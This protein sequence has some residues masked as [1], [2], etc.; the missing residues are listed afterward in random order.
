MC[1]LLMVVT[2]ATLGLS[3]EGKQKNGTDSSG[4]WHAKLLL[5]LTQAAMDSDSWNKAWLSGTRETQSL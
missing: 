1:F 3:E 4:M 5:R 2:R